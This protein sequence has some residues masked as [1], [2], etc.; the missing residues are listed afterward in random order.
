MLRRCRR[1]C[2]NGESNSAAPAPAPAFD[3]EDRKSC[4]GHL[5]PERRGAAQVDQR[6]SGS[7]AEAVRGRQDERDHGP[8]KSYTRGQSE[9]SAAF[10]RD[11]GAEGEV[12]ARIRE[13]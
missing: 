12:G 8:R 11:Q 1:S 13:G 5:R 3:S 10:E 4:G 2:A 6:G 7:A 9:P